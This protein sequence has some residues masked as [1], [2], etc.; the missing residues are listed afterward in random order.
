M[1]IKKIPTKMQH[2]LSKHQKGC[3]A[4]EMRRNTLDGRL[5]HVAFIHDGCNFWFERSCEYDPLIV[6]DCSTLRPSNN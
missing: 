2:R 5:L 1:T 6:S 4:Q 3:K